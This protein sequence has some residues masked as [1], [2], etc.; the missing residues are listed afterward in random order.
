MYCVC[1]KIHLILRDKERERE[2]FFPL[3]ILHLRLFPLSALLTPQSC[4]TFRKL[5][6]A[7]LFSAPCAL[8]THPGRMK[9]PG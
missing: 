9:W 3:T 8:H 6:Q 1:R 4:Y 7:P 5:P 2:T